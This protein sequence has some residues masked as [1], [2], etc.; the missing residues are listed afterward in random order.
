MLVDP[1]SATKREKRGFRKEGEER[2]KAKKDPK[3]K[4][5]E[6]SYNLLLWFPDHVTKTQM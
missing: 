5:P 4:K 6:Y 2:P 1:P 3:K